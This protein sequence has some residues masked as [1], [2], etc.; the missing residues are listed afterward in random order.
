MNISLRW[1]NDYLEPGDVSAE[2]ADRLLTDAGFPLESMET[3]PDGDVLLDVE[4]TSNRGDCLSHVGVAREIAASPRASKPRTLKPPPIPQGKAASTAAGAASDHL[5]LRNL[6]H[7][8]CPMFTAQV[9]RNVRVGPSPKW[10]VERLESIGQRSINSV[11]DVTNWLNFELGHPSH[12]FDLNT[13]A[14]PELV[15]RFAE[16]GETLTT[17]DGVARKVGPR[18]LVVADADKPVSLAGVIGGL[19]SQV[20]EQTTDVVLEVATWSPLHVRESARRHGVRTDASHRFER[21]VDARMLEPAARRAAA[22]LVE[23]AGGS[24][25]EGILTHGTGFAPLRQIRLR[26]DRCATILGIQIPT[27]TI[28][29][30]LEAHDIGVMKASDGALNC[31]IPPF[32]PDLT[33]EIDLIEEVA[34]THGYDQI[35]ISDR[36]PM[37]AAHPQEREG[38]MRQLATVL[39]GLGYH[40]TITFS[41]VRPDDGEAWRD[42][43]LRA[44][45]VDDE[46]RG[47][48]PMLRPSALPSLLRCR[49]GNQDARVERPGGV[50]LFETTAVFAETPEGENRERQTL[51]LL[52]DVAGEGPKRSFDDRQLGLR[53]MRGAIDALV[54]ATA[55]RGACVVVRPA[56][57]LSEGWDADA[58]AEVHVDSGAG[59][60]LLGRFGL[61]SA[62]ALKSAGVDLPQVA[63]ELDLELLLGFKPPRGGVQAPPAYPG[64][65]RDVSL[66]VDDGVAWADIARIALTTRDELLAGVSF[67]GAYRGK[68][69]GAGRKSVTARLHF[70]AGDRTL[71]HE[72][73]DPQAA[74]FAD[75]AKS[76][77][78]AEIRG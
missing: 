55:G 6:V 74:R 2:E 35:P 50:R 67:M 62:G 53:W 68:Q 58:H 5:T 71:R 36:L 77:L 70:R 54:H 7:H 21:T 32:R 29:E 14:G 25:C 45:A 37:V 10:L 15:I 66:V 65:D 42:P 57:P 41:F 16:A 19:D 13:L 28:A 63:A 56:E 26:P 69:V 75:S 64:I 1:L 9:I 33:R 49:R 78:G 38:A 51:A 24:L 34:R 30:H 39:T 17:L 44:L 46:R 47:A 3:L 59:E 60:V 12:V 73:V 52:A 48:E 31:T 8:E 27:E 76:E 72:E 43:A 11:V 23:L 18:D 22:M 4:V 61:V 20:T 40:E